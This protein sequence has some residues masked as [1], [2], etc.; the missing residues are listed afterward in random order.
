MEMADATFCI[1]GV[2]SL[3]PVTCFQ[4]TRLYRSPRIA[5]AGATNSRRETFIEMEGKGRKRG[6]ARQTMPRVR[7]VIL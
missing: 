5:I 1:S 3:A 7:E 2:P 4:K 6:N